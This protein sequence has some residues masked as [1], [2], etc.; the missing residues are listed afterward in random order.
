MWLLAEQL[1]SVVDQQQL[2]VVVVQLVVAAVIVQQLLAVAAGLQPEAVVLAEC[3]ETYL[4]ND[5]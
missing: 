5:T 3:L 1:V 2:F 4:F